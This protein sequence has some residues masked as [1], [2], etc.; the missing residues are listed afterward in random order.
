[1]KT[2]KLWNASDC[3]GK[4]GYSVAAYTQKQAVEL[5]NKADPLMR[6]TIHEFRTYYSSCWGNY[7]LGVMPELGVWKSEIKHNMNLKPVK[8][9]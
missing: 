6:T 4:Y 7:M 8:I 1:M 2:L 5:L 3:S 9:L